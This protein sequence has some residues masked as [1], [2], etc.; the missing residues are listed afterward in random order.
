MQQKLKS[1]VF[2]NLICADLTSSELNFLLY[3]THFQDDTGRITGVYYKDV[4]E[5][6]HVSYQTFYSSLRALQEKKIITY[7][8][9]NYDDWNITIQNNDFSYEGA[10]NEGYINMGYDLFSQPEFY[11]LKVQEKL[12]AIHII[13]TSGVGKRNYCMNWDN[14]YHK[15]CGIFQVGKRVL[16]SY[17]KRLK[18]FFSIGVKEG[19]VWITL[20]KQ[21]KNHSRTDKEA[22]T[23]HT[24]K[25]IWRRIRARD[26]KK[27]FN[28]LYKLLYQYAGELKDQVAEMV[29]EAAK[30]SL[31]MRNQGI[32]NTYKWNRKMD[33]RFI[34]YLLKAEL[35]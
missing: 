16:R 17:L 8:K 24:A 21:T 6:I 22:F 12:L 10:V 33:A 9:G 34:H 30:Q 4:C 13:K 25:T 7:K 3:L 14:F 19:K 26:D 20:L 1:R 28:E 11:A 15:F 32:K 23:K 31:A 5:A 18:G 29:M 35:S 2:E 27:D